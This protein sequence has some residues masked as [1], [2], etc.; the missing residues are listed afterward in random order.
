MNERQVELVMPAGHTLMIRTYGWGQ[1]LVLLHGFPLDAMIW[2]PCCE[3][4][5]A[6]G[7]QVFTPDLRG[8]GE[9]SDIT[10]PLSIADLADDIEQMRR[11][12]I[13]NDKI[14]LGGLSLGGYVAFE[15]WRKH[16]ERVRA[17]IL[18]NTKPQADTEEA[19]QGRLAMADKA[20]QESTWSAVSPMLSKLLSA[21]T[22]EHDSSTTQVIKTM[23]SEVPA[24]TVA[25]IQHAMADRADFSQQLHAIRIPTLIVT[26]EHDPISPPKENREWGAKIPNSRIEIL[27]GAAHLPQVEATEALCDVMIDFCK[28]LQ[29]S[30][31]MS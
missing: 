27:S 11:V 7:F 20:I 31:Q 23:M 4:L 1:P 28:H 25:A 30:H 8:F 14:I 21:H 26:G 16:S 13:G 29:A 5:V 9:S 18:S 10:E 22:L 15:Y 2:R 12:L 3:A 6:A 24:S 17:L 19:K